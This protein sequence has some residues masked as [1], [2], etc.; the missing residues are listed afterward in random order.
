MV[1]GGGGAKMAKSG[2]ASQGNKARAKAGGRT[3]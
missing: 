2:G 1:L 3:N